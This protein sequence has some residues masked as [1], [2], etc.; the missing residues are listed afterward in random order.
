MYSRKRA[1]IVGAVISGLIVLASTPTLAGIVGDDFNDNDKDTAKWGEDVLFGTGV[2]LQETNS[3]LQF[4]GTGYEGIVRPWTYSYGSY[5]SNW[6]VAADVHVG[7]LTLNQNEEIEMLLVVA[8]QGGYLFNNHFVVSLSFGKNTD[9]S[10]WRYYASQMMTNGVDVGEET[11]VETTNLQGRV[12][13]TFDATTKVLSAYYNG[14]PLGSH[15]VSSSWGTTGFQMALGGSFGNYQNDI[16]VN[17]TYLGSDVYADNFALTDT[18]ISPADELAITTSFADAISAYNDKN[19]SLFATYISEAFLDGGDTKT[20]MIASLQSPDWQLMFFT[21]DTPLYAGEGLAIAV[22]HWGTGENELMTFRKEGDT[23]LLYGDQNKYWVDFFTNHN[24]DNYSLSLSV[25]DDARTIISV[26]VDGPGLANTISLNYQPGGID[27]S[28]SW[29]SWSVGGSTSNLFPQFTAL[30]RPAIGAEYTLTIHETGGATITQKSRITGYVEDVATD[31]SPATGSTITIPQP[32][33]SWS[34]NGGYSSKVELFIVPSGD[35]HEF[36]WESDEPATS[37]L[38]YNGPELQ[39]NTN[40]CLHFSLMDGWGNISGSSVRFLYL[41]GT[42]A[43]Y[44]V[45]YN[46]NGATSGSAPASQIKTND[47]ALTLAGNTGNLARESYTF[48]G[49]NTAT[50]GTGTSYAT[51]VSYTANVALTLYAQWVVQMTTTTVPVPFTWLD[52]YPTLLS[53]HGGDYNI[54]ANAIGS[55]GYSVW[56]SYVAGLNPLDALDRFLSSIVITNNVVY[57]TWSPDLGLSRKYTLLGKTNLTD[58]TWHSPTNSG[59]SFFKLKVEM[60]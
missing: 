54:A 18:S 42:P 29:V 6:E 27:Q 7:D 32:N 56:E 25:E 10:T 16:P 36:V 51:N 43:T 47:V 40:Y 30:T 53:A 46:A 20:S 31:L 22:I 49:W 19:E 9:N 37:P 4:G 52:Q 21:M 60:P 38:T 34:T 57:I 2:N 28:P 1:K 50:N 14:N 45:T 48:S 39:S 41:G 59:S 11:W 55:N 23:W 8:P 35:I 15:V 5:T 33:F 24:A 3:R 17:M 12:S 44:A 26:D 58:S 13:I